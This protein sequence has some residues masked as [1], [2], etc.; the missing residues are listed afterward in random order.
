MT[1]G[2]KILIVDD[3]ALARADLHYMLKELPRVTAVTECSNGTEALEMLQEDVFDAV[4]LDIEMPGLNGLKAVKIINQLRNPP[5]V[6]FV[7]AYDE[8]AVKAFELNAVDYLVKPYSAKRL[9]QT[10]E[11]LLVV[12]ARLQ[13]RS[14][15]RT[16]EW[17]I[18]KT[19]PTPVVVGGN[20]QG[21]PD[22]VFK[23]IPVE[24]GD[25]VLL[26]S[27]SD[28]RYIEA[29]DD[30]VYVNTFDEQYLCRFSL[31]ELE[32]KLSSQGFARIHRSY[33]VNLQHV[34]ELQPFFNGTY[35]LFVD[36]KKKSTLPVSRARVKSLRSLIGV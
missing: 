15:R 2:L 25:G 20:T 28:V 6:V 10:V 18:A 8:H 5:L 36:D 17:E 34:L 33:I 1:D 21:Q 12:R 24:K 3:E 23:K 19:T 7:T 29:Y 30:K 4:F 31:T 16:P 13:A 11:K 26:I 32:N 9:E 22:T 35:T 14:S 27:L